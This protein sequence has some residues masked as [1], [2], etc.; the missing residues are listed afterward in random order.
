MAILRPSEI[1]GPAQAQAQAQ[2]KNVDVDTDTKSAVPEATSIL[3]Q[4]TLS[5]TTKTLFL[6]PDGAGSAFSYAAIPRIDS[7]LSVVALNSPYHRKPHLFRCALDDL[8]KSYIAEIRR[9]QPSGPYHFGGWSAGGILAYRA[10]QIMIQELHESVA[11]LVLIDSPVPTRGLDRLPQHFYDYC[12]KINVFGVPR[13]GAGDAG[14]GG[15]KP[16]QAPEWLIPHFNA[17][18]DTLHEYHAV[19]LVLDGNDNDNGTGIRVSIIWACDS[20]MDGADVPRP[21]SC[22]EDTEGMKFLTERRTDF[23]GCGWETLFPGCEIRVEK[24]H[25]ANHFTMMRGEFAPKLACFIRE[26]L[27]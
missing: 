6:F 7:S 8:L 1:S 15:N 26:S 25:G 4:G 10:A 21:P 22:P 23:S 5:K 12:N 16:A 20:V 2:D 13:G 17:T 19:P 3:L 9:R 18:I 27:F 14:G 11:S 24:A